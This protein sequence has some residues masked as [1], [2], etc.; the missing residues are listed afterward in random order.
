MIPISDE[1]EIIG[2][3]ADSVTLPRSFTREWIDINWTETIQLAQFFTPSGLPSSRIQALMRC[4]SMIC[5][6]RSLVARYQAP[7][8]FRPVQDSIHQ[9]CLRSLTGQRCT[10]GADQREEPKG[11]PFGDTFAGTRVVFP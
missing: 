8:T 1:R 7:L 3:H 2:E 5:G 9:S 10:D 6:A 4:Q 11:V